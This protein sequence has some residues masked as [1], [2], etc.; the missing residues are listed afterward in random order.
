MVKHQRRMTTVESV[1][2]TK[3]VAEAR[4]IAREVEEEELSR[5]LKEHESKDAEKA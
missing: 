2:A 1:E 5:K 3:M 4:R